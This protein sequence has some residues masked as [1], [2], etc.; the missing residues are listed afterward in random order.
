MNKRTRT[1][2]GTGDDRE[3]DL[4]AALIRDAG[5]RQEPPAEH[6]EDV[7]AATREAW[8]A[9]LASRRRRRLAY[10]LAASLALV[11]MTLGLSLRLE[12]PDPALV[13]VAS[14]DTIVGA[15]SVRSPSSPDWTR[16]DGNGLNLVS[17]TRLRVGVDAGAGLILEDGS[18]LRI[19]A[20]SEAVFEGPGRVRLEAGLVYIDTGATA[21][22][23][24]RVEVVT[25][26]GLVWDLGTQFEVGY[27]AD[28]LTIRVREGRVIV[29]R[30]SKEIQGLAGEALQLDETGRLQRTAI[31]PFG[32]EWRWVQAVA[33]LPYADQLTV[34]EL[35]EWVAR[36]TG[37]EVRFAESGL[38][39][40]AGRT[41]LHG[42]PHRLMPMEA[43]AVML[44]TTDLRYTVD[45]DGAILIAARP[46]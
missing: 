11:A 19:A 3:E 18:S 24:R 4:I 37:R 44:E 5:P 41:V 21:A 39:V 14:T 43:L 15:V 38:A 32:P 10:G 27:R 7:L 42:N 35:L 8:S 45:R 31:S 40:R 25:P 46:R 2:T 26:A 22:A 6:Y 20:D 12:N 34:H 1:D 17:G 33:P 9:K 30:D 16:L 36:E 28:A 29:E 23:A 13:I